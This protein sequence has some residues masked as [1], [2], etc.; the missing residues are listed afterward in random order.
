MR[1]IPYVKTILGDTETP[2]TVFQKYVGE[3]V[4][5]L[6]E[7]KSKE[8]N[9]FSFIGADPEKIIRSDNKEH[10]TE[11]LRKELGAF[12]VDNTTHLPFMGGVVGIMGYEQSADF[13]FIREFIAYDHDFGKILFVA[14]DTDDA[15]GKQ[16]ANTKL[17]A[18]YEKFQEPLKIVTQEEVITGESVS[19]TSKP[20]FIEKVEKAQEYIANGEITQVVLSQRW[21]AKSNIKPFELYRNLRSLNPSPYLFY[22][23]FGDCQAVGSSPEML[24]EIKKG[25]ISTCPIAGTR[26]RGA[27]E[28]EDYALVKELLADPK[29]VKE[30]I[31]LVDLAKEDMALV[32][33][34]ETI[35]V[36]DY[37][38]IHKFSHVMHITSLV[39]GEMNKD[40][41]CLE[42]L[43]SFFPAGTLSGAPRPRAM[44]IIEEL[45]NDKRGFY[46]GAAGYIGFTGEMDMC[47]AIRMMVVKDETIYMQAGAGIVDD[48][49]PVKE[50]EE[51][52]N[53]VKALINAI[54]M[55]S[56]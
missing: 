24:V 6:L 4:G 11:T 10:T 18:M 12:E 53:K 48:S 2:I 44:A 31:M 52:E 22:F 26:K 25:K 41:D 1:H 21:K 13:L 37:M 20:E 51:S 43:N 47:I 40:A 45:E 38:K 56:E 46:G 17:K 16:R 15:E 23:N 3:Q 14:L 39:E 54:Y 19:N 27:T 7:S 33:K 30:H 36:K 49:D 50:Y 8:N 42:V 32:A 28:D 55:R 5:F 35:K 34:E 9:R 29:E